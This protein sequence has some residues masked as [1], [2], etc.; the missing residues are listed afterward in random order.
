M[1]KDRVYVVFGIICKKIARCPCIARTIKMHF[2]TK[3]LLW[4]THVGVITCVKTNDILRILSENGMS[5]ISSK[6]RYVEKDDRGEEEWGVVVTGGRNGRRHGDGRRRQRL[7]VIKVYLLHSPQPTPSVLVR[8]GCS[9]RDDPSS[10]S[11]L[12]FSF[13]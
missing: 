13:F 5:T 2:F 4:L 8:A 3:H 1:V 12:N 10:N 9:Q 7:V 6:K 11:V